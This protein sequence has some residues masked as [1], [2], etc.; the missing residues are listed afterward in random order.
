M[1][2]KRNLAKKAQNSDYIEKP[3]A[4]YQLWSNDQSLTTLGDEVTSK[5]DQEFKSFQSAVKSTEEP[6]KDVEQKVPNE[7]VMKN[8]ESSKVY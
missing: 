3:E 8:N 6:N 2:Q 4:A 7:K 5:Q 1:Q